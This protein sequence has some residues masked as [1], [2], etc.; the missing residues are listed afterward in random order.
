M[1]LAKKLILYFCFMP[2]ITMAQSAYQE[3]REGNEAFKKNEFEQA[4]EKYR[5]SLRKDAD[6]IENSFNLGDALYRQ[7]KYEEASKFFQAVAA[8]SEDKEIKSKAFHNLG[9][10]LLKEKKLE[11]SIE[12]YKK[13][14]INNPKDEETRYN[15]AYAKQQ[16]QEQQK[17][18][19]EQQENK[20]ENKE[21]QEEQENKNQDQENK[22]EE[23]QDKEEQQEEKNEEQKEEEQKQQ[24]QEKEQ[25]VSRE[26]AE[27]ILEALNQD[28][29][30]LQEKLKKQKIKQVDINIEKDW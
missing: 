30:E 23:Q 17:Q 15:Y 16:L 24:Q 5:A 25:Q 21:E 10:S 14:L 12:A 27:R 9:N 4:E 19:Q 20:D 7:G 29:K 6:L 22:E 8:K 28:E 3:I 2:V 18:E 26:D 11:E 13:S 1:K